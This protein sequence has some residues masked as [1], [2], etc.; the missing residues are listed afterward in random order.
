MRVY[1][2]LFTPEFKVEKLQ[3]CKD[4]IIQQFEELAKTKSKYELFVTLD[5]VA[6]KWGEDLAKKAFEELAK[7]DEYRKEKI[8]EVGVVL[9]RV[10]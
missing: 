8:P 3:K 5:E 7:L 1:R 10:V 9:R 6:R 4:W 2:E